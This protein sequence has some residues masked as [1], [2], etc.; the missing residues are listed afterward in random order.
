MTEAQREAV[1]RIVREMLSDIES[2]APADRF[3]SIVW[4]KADEIIAA[5]YAAAAPDQAICPKCG[6]TYE[7]CTERA[8]MRIEGEKEARLRKTIA[9][10]DQLRAELVALR[11]TPPQER[12]DG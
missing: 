9:E 12:T 4:C 3:A 8:L 10:R 7:V 1:A 5:S 11:A 6:E 2:A